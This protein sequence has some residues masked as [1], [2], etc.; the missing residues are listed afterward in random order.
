M[1]YQELEAFKALSPSDRELKMVQDI[2]DTKEGVEQI[3]VILSS[4]VCP[5]VNCAL[6]DKVE[7]TDKQV[8]T[9]ETASETREKGKKEL[10]AYIA[11]VISACSL[12]AAILIR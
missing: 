11:I 10:V 12:A 2:S 7:D 1:D 9:M 6:R 8:D 5:F 4:K 3:T